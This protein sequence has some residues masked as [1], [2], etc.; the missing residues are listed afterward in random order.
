MTPRDLFDAAHALLLDFDGPIAALMPPPENEEA[1][2]AARQAIPDQDLPTEIATTSDHLAVLR[3]AR[4]NCAPE[5]LLG[6]EA[7]CTNTELLAARSCDE[8]PD[9]AALF[10]YA[11]SRRIPVA[12]VSNNSI[13]A[14]RHFLERRGWEGRIT[15]FACRTPETVDSLK[16]SPQ[17]LLNAMRVL[18][19]EPADALFVGDSPSDARAGQAAAVTIV[20]IAKDRFRERQLLEAG[21]RAVVARGCISRLFAQQG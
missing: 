4:A 11:G 20:G 9:A 6:V 10:E 2:T 5:V 19:I 14:V 1:A 7:A 3:W 21:A 8:S 12:I 16:P 15:A 17:L 18:G 13:A